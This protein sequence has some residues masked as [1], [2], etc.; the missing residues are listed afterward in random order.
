MILNL[1]ALKY[2]DYLF[3]LRPILFPPVWTIALLGYHRNPTLS[4]NSLSLALLWLTLLVGA[5]YLLN[6]VFDLPSDR[7][8]KKL[9]FLTEGHLPIKSAI[10]E[11]IFLNLASI[12]GAFLISYQLGIF[13][14]LGFCLGLLYSLPPGALKNKPWG[15]LLANIAGHG[16]LTF[17]IGWQIKSDISLQSLVYSLPYA[18]AVGAVYLNT[19]LPDREGDKMVG[20]ETLGVKWGIKNT[21]L[22]A[23]V[24]VLVTVIISF[25]FQD[26]ILFFPSLV[27]LVFFIYQNK[28]LKIKDIIT[29]S[30]VS[31]FTLSLAAVVA[32]P[33]YFLV[34]SLVFILTRLYYQIRFGI[35]YPTW[36]KI[37]VD[38]E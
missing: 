1:R 27:S 21:S 38:K 7:E 22:L 37:A 29:A 3:V 33:L 20:K 4:S 36:R 24:L 19:T 13:F 16:I 28:T 32:Y 9:F 17:Q 31:V 34:L 23:L 11:I 35:A 15:G 6:Q 8:N 5:V 12:S 2:L 18:L 30:K 10:L 26:W 14:F 25:W